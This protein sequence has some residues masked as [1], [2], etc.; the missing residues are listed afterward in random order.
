LKATSQR[1]GLI[2]REQARSTFITQQCR[3]IVIRQLSCALIQSSLHPFLLALVHISSWVTADTRLPK[4]EQQLVS[5]LL[6][7]FVGGAAAKAG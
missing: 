1:T 3:Q 6:E 2:P 4:P 5:Q 7:K